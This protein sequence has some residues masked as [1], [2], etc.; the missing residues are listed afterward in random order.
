MTGPDGKQT[1][2]WICL[3]FTPNARFSSPPGSFSLLLQ[4]L[5]RWGEDGDRDGDRGKGRKGQV[6]ISVTSNPRP[7]Q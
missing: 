2:A 6:N 4:H 5:G 7:D 1:I 3:V